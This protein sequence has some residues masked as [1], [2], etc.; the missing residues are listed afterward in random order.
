M[1]ESIYNLIDLIA[2]GRNVEATDVLNSEL[3]VRAHD[4]IDEIRP[5]VASSYFSPILDSDEE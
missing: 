1:S 5:E 2:Q 3:M 4:R